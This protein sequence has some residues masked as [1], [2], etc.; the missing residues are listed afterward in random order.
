MPLLTDSCDSTCG[1]EGEIKT[2]QDG[3]L[4]DFTTISV[5]A[6]GEGGAEGL[7]QGRASNVA[8]LLGDIVT[9]CARVL[10]PIPRRCSVRRAPMERSLRLDTRTLADLMAPVTS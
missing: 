1:L 6:R 2:C 4:F 8:V 9:V 3:K 5:C 7:L 10:I